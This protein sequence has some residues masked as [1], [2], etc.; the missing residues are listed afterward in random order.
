MVQG[1]MPGS[2]ASRAAISPGSAPGS[3]TAARW[4]SRRRARE[5]SA[6]GP[7]SARGRSRS[8]SASISG[9]GK[10][11]VSPGWPAPVARRR[12]RDTPAS[13]AVSGGGQR[14]AIPAGQRPREGA[15][16]GDRDLLAEDR[17][18]GQLEAV[19]GAGHPQPGPG[20][21]QRGDQVVGGQRGADRGRDRRRRRAAAGPGRP[22]GD[23][24]E[25]GEPG[26]EQHVALAW[27]RDELDDP[28][29]RGGPHGPGV[30]LRGDLL[31]P[32]DGPRGQ[33]TQPP[34]RVERLAAGQ[35]EGEPRAGGPGRIPGALAPGP[36]RRAR[37]RSSDG[38]RPEDSR[39]LALNCRTLEKPLA[40]A[41]SVIGMAV[42]ASSRRAV[43]SR[44]VRPGP[45]ARRPARPPAA[46]AGAAG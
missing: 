40:N 29:A 16:R 14:Y 4:R 20:P 15:R 10:T 12:A 45:A 25:P 11:T 37:A 3:R 19:V 41:T 39:T 44:A 6:G 9:P 46:G 27:P 32:G 42:S 21:H 33:E 17:A 34:G 28:R 13:I 22:P 36:V 2:S 30:A 23:R 8:A 5:G 7:W 43:C 18:D 38:V 35:P 26:P 31:H 24:P 1:P